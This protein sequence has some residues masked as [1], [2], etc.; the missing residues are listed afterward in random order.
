MSWKEELS[1]E[2]IVLALPIACAVV[3]AYL[4]GYYYSALIA[5][6]LLL[7]VMLAAIMEKGP[8]FSPS[9]LFSRA[10]PGEWTEVMG[11]A[12]G[13][14][15][16]FIGFFA[17]IFLAWA[18]ANVLALSFCAIYYLVLTVLFML[19]RIIE[20]RMPRES[21]IAV[22]DFGHPKGWTRG[23]LLGLVLG[24]AMFMF[25]QSPGPIIPF[26]VFAGV[27]PALGFLT[28]VVAIPFVEVSFFRGILTP[29]LAEHAGII[30]ALAIIVPLFAGFHWLV[31]GGIAA[32]LALAAT[33]SL[34]A[35]ILVLNQRSL[36]P[37]LAGHMTF[38]ALGFLATAGVFI[39]FM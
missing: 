7:I 16:L 38:N 10:R 18:G 22:I 34:F 15:I 39:P 3:I 29:T 26:Q 19:A 5:G 12:A 1:R 27:N 2:G 14:A 35:S 24:V 8:L 36:M 6:T 20:K 28:A 31:F 21:E 37:A 32:T 11:G 9:N 17:F 33:Y 25:T 4:T 13:M 30:A 23:A